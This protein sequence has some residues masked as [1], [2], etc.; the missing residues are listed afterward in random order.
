MKVHLNKE[1][2]KLSIKSLNRKSVKTVLFCFFF[3]FK[4]KKK[5]K[6]LLMICFLKTYKLV[7]RMYFLK[8]SI[9][10]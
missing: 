9:E 6:S 4:K 1:K 3:Y 8:L 2:E 7:I 5:E 10:K